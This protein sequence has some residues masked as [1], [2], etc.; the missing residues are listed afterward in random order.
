MYGTGSSQSKFKQQDIIHSV[1]AH[2][3]YKLAAF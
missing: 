3:V 2:F 1:V